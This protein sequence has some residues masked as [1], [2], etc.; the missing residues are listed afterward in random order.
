MLAQAA[1]AAT[2]WQL[3]GP[4]GGTAHGVRVAPSNP[5]TV[6]VFTADSQI[7]ASQNRGMEWKPQVFPAQ[8]G[9]TMHALVI[10]A[11]DP[12]IWLAGVE[13]DQGHLSGLYRTSDAGANWS[14]PEELK[15]SA[16]WSLAVSPAHPG[17]AIAGTNKG[18]YRST[19]RGETWTRISDESYVDLRPVVSVAIDP[20]DANTIVAGTTHL[21]WRTTDGGKTWDS[22]H[23]GMLDDSDVFSMVMHPQTAGIVYASACSGA[24]RSANGGTQWARL[25]TPRGTFRTYV[26]AVDASAPSTVYAGT[27]G[28]L[29]R[30]DD[31]GKTW[32]R[33]SPL[34]VYSIDFERAPQRRAYF[35]SSGGILVSADG[36]K[37]VQ[38]LSRGFGNRR[39]TQLIGTE[40]NLYALYTQGNDRGLYKSSDLGRNWA[41]L[42]TPRA[43]IISFLGF[44]GGQGPVYISTRNQVYKSNDTGK[45]WL[46]VGGPITSAPIDALAAST[47]AAKS[48]YV[49]AG[50]NL[51]KSTAANRMVLLKASYSGRIRTIDVAGATVTFTTRTGTGFSKDRGATWQAC[52]TPNPDIEWYDASWVKEGLLI[53]ATSH[54]LLKSTDCTE[55]TTVRG[56]LEASTVSAFFVDRTNDSLVVSQ[57]GLI[58]RSMDEG[59]GWKAITEPTGAK[60]MPTQLLFLPNVRDRMFALFPRGGVAEWPLRPDDLS[61]GPGGKAPSTSEKK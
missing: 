39:W 43:G 34:S 38:E 61:A 59:M 23:R 19:D 5:E 25:A 60:S 47:D 31:E 52:R 8:H 57:S 27:S 11:Q 17:L 3:L 13:D 21:P 14:T 44:T 26:V 33:L 4:Y 37:K 22:I 20:R 10:D 51:Y 12:K 7:F 45:T 30:S 29:L 49:A 32:I 16:V 28:G 2:F 53:A 18:V 35:A 50:K 55:W 48:V 46:P 9:T 24:Y 56:G 1:I 58:F 36:E 40:N 42:T 15:G 41:Q 54:G 6:V